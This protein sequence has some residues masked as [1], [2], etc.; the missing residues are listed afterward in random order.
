L[1]NIVV[2]LATKDDQRVYYLLTRVFK[3]FSF[4]YFA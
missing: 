3:H 2:Y 1:K 4:G